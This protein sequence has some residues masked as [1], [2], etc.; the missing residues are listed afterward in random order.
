MQPVGEPGGSRTIPGGPEQPVA[1]IR[2]TGTPAGGLEPRVKLQSSES[3]TCRRRRGRLELRPPVGTG[4]ARWTT[5][6]KTRRFLAPAHPGE[7][8]QRQAW[9]G[10]ALSPR[11][12]SSRGLRGDGAPAA[13]PAAGPWS[14]G[15]LAL[16]CAILVHR[17][18]RWERT[19]FP[20]GQ[21]GGDQGAAGQRG[22]PASEGQALEARAT[23]KAPLL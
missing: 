15:P 18:C 19:C 7:A 23:Q 5:V 21:C 10:P 16:A 3:S 4:T 17:F 22:R 20:R 12:F 11:H 6:R 2:E 1:Q 8:G 13:V 9:H 14:A